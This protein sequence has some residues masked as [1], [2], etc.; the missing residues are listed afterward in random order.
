MR[1][2]HDVSS[3]AQPVAVPANTRPALEMGLVTKMG[4][5]LKKAKSSSQ[6]IAHLASRTDAPPIHFSRRA[7]VGKAEAVTITEEAKQQA[8][9]KYSKEQLSALGHGPKNA[10]VNTLTKYHRRW[11]GEDGVPVLPLTPEKG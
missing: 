1:P 11:H 6:D 3:I 10:C 2:A 5:S 9:D 8:L 4:P 7:D